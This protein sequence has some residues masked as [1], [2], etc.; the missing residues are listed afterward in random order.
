[1]K[2][3]TRSRLLVAIAEQLEQAA[4]RIENIQLVL[5]QSY[6]SE[7]WSE[8]EKQ[9]LCDPFVRELC[10]EAFIRDMWSS[11]FR[12]CPSQYYYSWSLDKRQSF[13]GR[14]PS[15]HHLCKSL[16][17]E[18]TKYDAKYAT[19][20]YYEK[21]YCCII[22]YSS[23][24]DSEGVARLFRKH[25]PHVSRKYFNFQFAYDCE[26]VTGYSFNAV[27]PLGMKSKMTLVISKAVADL[28]PPFIWLGGGREDVKWFVH[29]TQLVNAFQTI[30][31]PI[32][33]ASK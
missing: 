30:V 14:V 1:M 18:N 5:L 8:E 24:L 22:Q 16:V 29:V 21:Y 20:L 4:R 32:D 28:Q 17:I 2:D 10:I 25:M 19:P 33:I 6:T 23:K 27:T 11:R 9:A 12:L 3:A 7:D 13:L 15:I 31:A 26:N